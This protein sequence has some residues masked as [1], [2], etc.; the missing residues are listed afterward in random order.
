MNTLT[1][2][3]KLAQK[4]DLV[5]IPRKEY[6]ALLNFKRAREFMPTS[7][8]KR[9]LVRAEKNFNRKKTLS[10]NELARKLGFAN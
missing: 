3:R 10:Y 4:D 5:I 7:V 6:E 8:Q 9:A 2:P 1:I